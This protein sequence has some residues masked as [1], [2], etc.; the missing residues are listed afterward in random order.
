MNL[1]ANAAVGGFQNCLQFSGS[2]VLNPVDYVNGLA[3]AFVAKGGQIF[4]ETRVRKPDNNKVT[5]MA[6][7]Q[8]S[9]PSTPLHLVIFSLVPLFWIRSQVKSTAKRVSM[10][11]CTAEHVYILHTA[12]SVFSRLSLVFM[13]LCPSNQLRGCFIISYRRMP[14]I[15]VFKVIMVKDNVA[16]CMSMHNVLRTMQAFKGH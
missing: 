5:T 4:E 11:T 7:N 3:E 16:G 8:V 6:G 14:H 13:F 12:T 10:A 9:N 2:A 1:G 15:D